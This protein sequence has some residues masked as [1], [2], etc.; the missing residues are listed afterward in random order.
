MT[1]RTLGWGTQAVWAGEHRARGGDHTQVPVVHSVSYGYDDVDHWTAVAL[2]DQ[3]G[4]IYGRNTNPT[5]AVLEEKLRVMEGGEAATSAATGMAAISNTLFA[6]LAP[7]RRVVSVKDTYG[8]TNRVFAEFLPRYGVGVAL[9]DTSDHEQIE[10][11]IGRGCSLLYLETPTNPTLKVL[12]LE[13][14]SAA[15]HATGAVVVVDNTVATPINQNPLALGADLVIHSATKYLGGHNDLLAGAIVG[16]AA[17]IDGIRS[18]QAVLGGVIDP[19]AAYLLIRGLKTF[20]LRIERQNANAQALA[21]FLQAHQ[22]VT[23]VHYAGLPSHPEHEIAK[24]QMRGFGGVV[25]F[26]IDGD[27]AATS[28]II[29]AFRIPRIA[30]SLGGVES[31]IE[32]PALMSFYELTTDERL[33]V[34]IKD[35]LIRYSV[36]VED[37]DDLIADLAAALDTR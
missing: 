16:S 30:P 34:G 7:G 20:P 5:V 17:L 13:R 18:M 29:D 10:T 4:H 15:G 35:N 6:L 37:A 12:D 28:R 3:P 33:M 1:E 27:L 23:I 8:G 22:R 31:L 25:S 21:E 32:Q 2:G 36:G 24:R 14:L 26:E 19:F 9:C 11:E